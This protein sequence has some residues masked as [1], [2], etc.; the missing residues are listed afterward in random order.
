[1]CEVH[2]RAWGNKPA[3]E[4]RRLRARRRLGNSTIGDSGGLESLIRIHFSRISRPVF[5]PIHNPGDRHKSGTG[6]LRDQVLLLVPPVPLHKML[7]K[8]PEE[9]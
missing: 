3:H 1:M 9:E 7:M 6:D 5:T 8:D 4:N 2:V